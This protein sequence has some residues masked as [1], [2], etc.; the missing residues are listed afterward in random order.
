MDILKT[1]RALR[2]VNLSMTVFMMVSIKYGLLRNTAFPPQYFIVYVFTVVCVMA[3]GYL[4]NDYHDVETDRVNKPAKNIF[5]NASPGFVYRVSAPLIALSLLPLLLLLMAGVHD[6][7]IPF[8]INCVALLLLYAYA[9]YGKSSVLWGN[10][11]VAFMGV[12]LFWATFFALGGFG[13]HD[14][15]QVCLL[16][17]YAGFS[18]GITLVREIVKDAEDAEGDHKAGIKT[19]ATEYGDKSVKTW[20]GITS[21]LVILLLI[22][23]GAYYAA[24]EELYK[25]MAFFVLA[26]TGIFTLFKLLQAHDKSGFGRT[27]TWLK[28]Y[29]LLGIISMWI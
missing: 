9:R 25:G 10:L 7:Y 21:L 17:L 11:L 4:I 8:A 6:L 22:Y 24:Y 15:E 19:L 12:L 14:N 16:N 18:F 23:M 1:I 5:E 20:A 28:V 13:M 27:S 26:V 2:P 3:F 29:M